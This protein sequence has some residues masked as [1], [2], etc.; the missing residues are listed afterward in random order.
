MDF[1]KTDQNKLS[2]ITERRPCHLV[3]EHGPVG[4]ITVN[5]YGY[6]SLINPIKIEV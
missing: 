1:I 2:V 3:S 4:Q 6:V 5:F